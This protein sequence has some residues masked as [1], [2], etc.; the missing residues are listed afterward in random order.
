MPISKTRTNISFIHLSIYYSGIHLYTIAFVRSGYNRYIYIYLSRWLPL[1]VFTFCSGQQPL[2][3]CIF[4]NF[5]RFVFC[6]PFPLT[7][8][9]KVEFR[10]E[11]RK[12]SKNGEPRHLAMQSDCFVRQH[13]LVAV[14]PRRP[15]GYLHRGHLKAD[16]PRLGQWILGPV[17]CE[18]QEDAAMWFHAWGR[19]VGTQLPPQ[20]WW[21]SAAQKKPPW[22]WT[23]TT[24]LAAVVKSM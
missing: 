14:G 8:T 20:T 3:T 16:F 10:K 24:G 23:L 5:E 22:C 2:C 15:L 9:Y 18:R 1:F 13:E 6:L 7:V 21:Y 19:S 12:K 11:S 4:E 17:L